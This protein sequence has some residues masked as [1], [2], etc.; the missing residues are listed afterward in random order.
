MGLVV[1]WQGPGD[2]RDGVGVELFADSGGL[3]S[4]GSVATGLVST[5]APSSASCVA[6]AIAAVAGVPASAVATKRTTTIGPGTRVRPYQCDLD[7]AHVPHVPE[8]VRKSRADAC[9]ETGEGTIQHHER[10]CA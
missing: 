8:L 7:S 5:V 6:A 4:S 10:A 1:G 3:L 9:W 2:L